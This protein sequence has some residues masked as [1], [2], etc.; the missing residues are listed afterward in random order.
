M[1]IIKDYI[2]PIVALALSI[3]FYISARNSAKKAEKLLEQISTATK[4]WQNDIMKFASDL[5]NS[6]PTVVGQK[7]IF[8]KLK[9]AEELTPQI[10]KLISELSTNDLS[11]EQKESKRKDIKLLLDYKYHFQQSAFGNPQTVNTQ[12][13]FDKKNKDN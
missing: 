4:T 11:E 3:L 1:D 6:T 13:N 8:S 12:Q 7:A 10:D 5:L 2:L 9:A